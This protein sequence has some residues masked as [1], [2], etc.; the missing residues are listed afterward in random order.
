MTRLLLLALVALFAFADPAAAGIGLLGTLVAGAKT[1]WAALGAS[2]FGPSV[3]RIALGLASSA[4]SRMFRKDPAPAGVLR[5]VDFGGDKP[6]RV[7]LGYFAGAGHLV[8]SGSHGQDGKTPNAYFTEVV[9]LSVLPIDAVTGILVNGARATLGETAHPDYGLPVLEY[10]V[11]GTDYLWVKIKD[12]TQTTPD[13]MLLATYGAG[14]GN[15]EDLPWA[16]DMIARGCAYAIITTRGNADLFGGQPASVVFETRGARLYD[17][18]QDST[19]GGSGPQRANDRSTWAWSANP[20][21][22]MD[23]VLTMGLGWEDQHLYGPKWPRTMLP[24]AS[25]IAAANACDALTPGLDGSPEPFYRFGCDLDL[26]TAPRDWLREMLKCAAADFALCEGQALIHVGAPS[27]P[28]ASLADADLSRSH[29]SE[30]DPFKGLEEVF[31]AAAATFPDPEQGWGMVAAPTPLHPEWEAL[32]GGRRS[33]TMPYPFVPWV[34]QVQRLVEAA[35]KDQRRQRVHRLVLGWRFGYLAPL[36]YVAWTSARNGYAAKL[37]KVVSVRDYRTGHVEVL[38]LEE[39]PDDFDPPALLPHTPAAP[40]LTLPAPQMVPGFT[41]AAVTT[42]VSGAVRRVGIRVTWDA[43]A[44][45]DARGVRIAWR[46]AGDTADIVLPLH[47]VSAGA[48]QFGET[49]L[50]G[51]YEVR[52]IFDAD[53]PVVWTPWLPVTLP[54]TRVGIETLDAELGT[55]LQTLQDWIAAA[56]S[57]PG[58]LVTLAGEVRAQ[59]VWLRELQA[60]A[61]EMLVRDHV[62]RDTLRTSLTARMGAMQAEYVGQITALASDLDAEALRI[63]TLTASVAGK[64]DASAVSGLDTR[65][66]VA[67]S[68]I[69]SQGT[70]ITAINTALPGKA[71]AS[72]V[73]ALDTRMTAAEGTITSQGTAITAINTALPGKADAS[74]LSTLSATVATQGGDITTLAEALT[75]VSAGTTAG[76]TTTAR[77]RMSAVTGPT[78]YARVAFEARATTGG[79]WRAAGIYLDAPTNEALPTRVIIAADQFAISGGGT[80]GFPFVVDGGEVRVSVPIVSDNYAESGGIPTDG[81]RLDPATGTIKAAG[82]IAREAI[83]DGAVSDREVQTFA[84]EYPPASYPSSTTDS[85]VE[86][87][88]VDLG[89][90]ALGDS[91]Q[92]IA[93]CEVRSWTYTTGSGETLQSRTFRGSFKLLRSIKKTSGDSWSTPMALQQLYADL[94]ATDWLGLVSRDDMAGAYYDTRYTLVLRRDVSGSA[95]PPSFE[96]NHRDAFIIATR[97]KR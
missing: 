86:L 43:D 12:G 10:R 73:S 11:G 78:G 53:R 25:W 2:A 64:A 90:T 23:T 21:V 27:A 52:A 40:A 71:D 39:D 3:A 63:D 61:A 26:S 69:T 8:W 14:T 67:E 33:A 35:L 82:V 70:A 77:L 24:A 55:Q 28:V 66:T 6:Q 30:L 87:F 56:P 15:A 46:V 41:A 45:E 93:G 68:T 5:R 79:T 32:D 38:L 47:P 1:A 65:V 22:A 7:R 34:S 54:E 16:A 50:A 57:L 80:L 60:R 59:R 48:A 19:A 20:V 75:A 96:A 29:E 42:V 17:R 88:S 83:I 37:F 94:G 72:A 92:V 49:L 91:W 9:L 85:E 62:A 74:A 81:F 58:S 18:R 13:P 76:D 97:I 4:I 31:N 84:G 36:D 95:T 51:A 44:A 89:P